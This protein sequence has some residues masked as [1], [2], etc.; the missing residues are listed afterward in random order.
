MDFEGD[1][2]QKSGLTEFGVSLLDFPSFLT[3]TYNVHSDHRNKKCLFGPTVRTSLELLPRCVIDSFTPCE[4]RDA[5]LV[6]HAVPNEVF[7]LDSLQIKIEELPIT[8]IID[9]LTLAKDVL[10]RGRSLEGLM[11]ILGIETPR[12]SIHTAGNDAHYTLQVLL[13]L[14]QR[15]YG[16]VLPCV[17]D[18]VRKA[19]PPSPTSPRSSESDAD[20][21]EHLDGAG[22]F[23]EFPVT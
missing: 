12:G 23:L 21:E 7:A 5:I 22:G 4:G 1:A 17:E 10:G 15:K 3:S 16:K 6:C 14:L 2:T 8:G 13:A 11:T 18:I 20:W 9:T 19:L